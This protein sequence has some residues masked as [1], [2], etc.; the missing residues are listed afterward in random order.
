MA[1]LRY[2]CVERFVDHLRERASNDQRLST[3]EVIELIESFPSLRI[4]WNKAYGLPEENDTE[5]ENNIN[6]KET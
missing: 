1:A 4:D 5:E 2:V 3:E 6:E